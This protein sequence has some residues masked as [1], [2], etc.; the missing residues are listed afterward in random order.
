MSFPVG[1][2]VKDV[3]FDLGHPGSDVPPFGYVSGDKEENDWLRIKNIDRDGW[4]VMNPKIIVL[5]ARLVL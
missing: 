5:H 4:M 3:R 1:F 2:G